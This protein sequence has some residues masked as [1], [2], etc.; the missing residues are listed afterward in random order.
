M[1]DR[2]VVR[3]VLGLLGIACLSGCVRSFDSGHA[4]VLWTMAGGT[5]PEVY[6]EGVHL[7]APWNR[8]TSYD[9]RTQDRKEVLHV[10]TNNGLS[11]SLEASRR[12][13]ANASR[14]RASQT[15]RRS[16]P[17]ASVLSSCAGRGSRP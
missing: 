5:Q 10:L 4:G 9:V 7:I 8:L 2:S 16:W 13:N 1:G 17:R 12:R 15:S 6:G 3:V 11:V 14:P